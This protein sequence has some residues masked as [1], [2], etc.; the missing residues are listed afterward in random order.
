VTRI[1][2]MPFADEHLDAAAG[3]LAA[4]HRVHREW[5]PLLDA[6]YEQP[7]AAREAIARE[8]RLD[9][10]SGAAALQRGT[11][12]G[13]LIAAPQPGEAWGA[14]VLV[15]S[16]GAAAERA[17][18]IR[19]L[20]GVAAQRW[21]DE[22]HHRHY[23]LVPAGPAVW[24]D[25]WW[26]LSFGCQQVHGIQTVRDTAWPDGVRVATTDD[27]D[28]LVLLGH[29]VDE[30]HGRSPVFSTRP[31]P[32]DEELRTALAEDVVS[33]DIGIL[34][35]EVD[36]RVAGAF[37]VAPVELSSTHSGPARPTGQCLLS[38][39]ATLPEVRGSGVGSALAAAC[40][41]WAHAAGYATMVTDWRAT[42][43]LASR[44]W[45]AR[46]DPAFLRL[47]RSVP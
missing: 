28:A 38:F 46:F 6:S 30:V 8:W 9:G 2:T 25:A 34:V 12:V 18:T 27:V 21:V 47:Y 29:A 36:G 16:A 24:L 14:N 26:R 11:L 15:G 22:G 20:Y 33:P 23:A 7:A 31:A 32:S 4:R 19:D 45:P 37:E 35:A 40:M 10:A 13:Y 17:E 3:L 41:A 39:G 42:N 43:L 44:F 1:E 5:S